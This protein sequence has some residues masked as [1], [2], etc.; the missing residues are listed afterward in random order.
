MVNKQE[1]KNN[2]QTLHVEATAMEEG[3]PVFPLG[4]QYPSLDQLA[5]MIPCILQY[6]NFSTII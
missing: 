1:N 4:Y 3:A 2:I 5:D 6:L